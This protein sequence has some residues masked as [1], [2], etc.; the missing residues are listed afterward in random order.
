MSLKDCKV[1][2]AVP[3]SDMA[4]AKEFYEGTLGLE[5]NEQGDEMA[6]YRVRRRHR[7]LRLRHRAR[8][9]E[10]G[11]A[12]RLRGLRL[13]R[14]ARRSEAAR[15]RPS[16]AT[17]RGDVKTDEKGVIDGGGFK[18]AFFKDPDGNIFSINGLV[19]RDQVD[20]EDERG[21]RRDVRRLALRR[22]SRGRAGSRAGGWPPTFMPSR[23]S[24]QPG[25]T[26]PCAEHELERLAASIGRVEL[27]AV[28]VEDADVVDRELSRPP[29]P[30]RLRPPRGPRSRALYGGSPSGISTVGLL[31]PLG[32]AGSS[33]SSSPPPWPIRTTTM[34]TAKSAP[35]A[36]QRLHPA[37]HRGAHP[38]PARERGY[39]QPPHGCPNTSTRCTRSRGPIR[40]TRRCSRTS[41]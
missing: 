33:D 21:V 17:T 9:H 18:V 6:S 27:L 32:G 4:R 37:I 8:R 36:D 22:R 20:H 14:R 35:R 15:R 10:Q 1:G 30:R 38:K 24:S 40:R 2:T 23:P 31:L 34:I 3:V 26:P 28:V 41:R 5:P 29:G 13:R 39:P 16:S 19:D 7:P 12:R 25:I 11:D